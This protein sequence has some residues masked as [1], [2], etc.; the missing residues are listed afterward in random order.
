VLCAQLVF[1]GATCVLSLVGDTAAAASTLLLNLHPS[2]DTIIPQ[3]Q[4]HQPDRITA[5]ISQLQLTHQ[6]Q[7]RQED[8]AHPEATTATDRIRHDHVVDG[9]SGGNLFN[10]YQLSMQFMLYALGT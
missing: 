9:Q 5:R 3:S 10:F 6:P 4:Q 2:F 8:V 1:G 7:G